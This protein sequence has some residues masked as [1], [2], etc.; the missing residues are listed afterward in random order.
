MKR[1]TISLDGD[2][3]EKFDEFKAEQHRSFDAD[4]AKALLAYG[5]EY[6]RQ[7]KSQTTPQAAQG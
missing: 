1:I 2:L 4:A 6:L 5:L 7:S 3:E